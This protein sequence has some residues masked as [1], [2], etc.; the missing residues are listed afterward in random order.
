[1]FFFFNFEP[2]PP[3]INQGKIL[4]IRKNFY[5]TQRCF[6]PDFFFRKQLQLGVSGTDVQNEVTS[7]AL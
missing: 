6:N 5:Y 4:P 1:M 2:P 7:G 3:K